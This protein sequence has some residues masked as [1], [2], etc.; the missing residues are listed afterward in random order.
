MLNAATIL[1]GFVCFRR[2]APP[3]YPY[4]TMVWVQFIV[5]VLL[6]SS[7]VQCVYCTPD[8][9]APVR[10]YTCTS[11]GFEVTCRYQ[12]YSYWEMVVIEP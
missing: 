8:V 9:K 3:E 11:T 2:R 6:M 5:S 7:S 4:L 12:V 10:I 1:Y